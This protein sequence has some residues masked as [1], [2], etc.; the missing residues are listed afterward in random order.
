MVSAVWNE[1]DT[2]WEVTTEKGETVRARWVV[3]ATGGLSVPHYPEID[4]L[5]D[6]RG[7]AHHTGAWPHTPLD[8]AGKRVAIIGNGP[9]GAQLLPA[10]VDIVEPGRPLPAHADLD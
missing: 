9:S 8:F 4:G 6:F 3:S 10:I 1:S 7:E 2:L 5:D